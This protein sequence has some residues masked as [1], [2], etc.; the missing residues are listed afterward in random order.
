MGVPLQSPGR[1]GMVRV[2]PPPAA[3][4]PVCA[5]RKPSRGHGGRRFVSSCVVHPC[6]GLERGRGVLRSCPTPRRPHLHRPYLLA[7]PVGAAL[8]PRHAPPALCAKPGGAARAAVVL[9]WR[10]W[11]AS[12]C[13][14][15]R[16]RRSRAPL[17]PIVGDRDWATWLPLNDAG[18]GGVP[19]RRHTVDT[20]WA[21]ARSCTV[22]TRPVSR[23]SC[24]YIV[25]SP[26][27]LCFSLL[28]CFRNRQGP[29][30]FIPNKRHEEGA[31]SFA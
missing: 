13:S 6:V 8:L 24:F 18:P 5:F 29:G 4:G 31:L 9:A 25:L 2:S 26:S 12:R 1:P 19:G 16:G 11:R 30:E 20:R 22:A 10:A 27:N 15:P 14:V 7:L 21:H 28:A 17:V 23:L 3:G